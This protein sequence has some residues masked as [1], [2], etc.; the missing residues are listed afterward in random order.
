MA[1]RRCRPLPRLLQTSDLLRFVS[2]AALFGASFLFMRLAAPHFGAILTAELRV[3][4]GGIVLAAAA[5]GL[6]S[7][8]GRSGNP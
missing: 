6:G 4:I 2:L 7:A 1:P 8:S 3:L 5:A